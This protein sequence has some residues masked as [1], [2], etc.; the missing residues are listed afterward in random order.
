M[1]NIYLDSH[2]SKRNES[3][4]SVQ[5]DS[6]QKGWK[7]KPFDPYS[8]DFS[9]H[10]FM[11]WSRMEHVS[12]NSTGFSFSKFASFSL[13]RSTSLCQSTYSTPISQASW[14]YLSLWAVSHG[15]HSHLL[16]TLAEQKNYP[17]A[18]YQTANFVSLPERRRREE[19]KKTL[20]KT[21]TWRKEI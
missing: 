19:K 13:Q 7:L 9:T 10:S 16:M 14:A 17:L 6:W 8:P 15:I 18:V 5:V 3:R 1:E 12:L 21:P 11:C 4:P 20:V 2:I